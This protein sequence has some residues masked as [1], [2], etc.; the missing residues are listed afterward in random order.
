[1]KPKFALRWSCDKPEENGK[2]SKKTK[3]EIVCP[4]GYDIFSGKKLFRSKVWES[5]IKNDFKAENVIFMYAEKVEFG[6]NQKIFSC[7]AYPMVRFRRWKCSKIKFLIDQIAEELKIAKENVK[8]FET[9]IKNLENEIENCN[10][11]VLTEW[12]NWSVCSCEGSS[13]KI[14]NSD[15]FFLQNFWKF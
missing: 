15:E 11:P 1:M 6:I 13:L 2:V 5:T 10:K 7:F 4:D 3:C 14:G 8:K 12:S 9:K